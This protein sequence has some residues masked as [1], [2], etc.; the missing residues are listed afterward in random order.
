MRPFTVPIEM[1]CSRPG[2]ATFRVFIGA[3]APG[4]HPLAYQA[5]WLREV[6]GAGIE[7]EALQAFERL[8]GVAREA[9]VSFEELCQ[10]SLGH[11]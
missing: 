3:P 2:T 8:L 10:R 7:A 1:E 6:H 4:A 11:R 9:G 5:A